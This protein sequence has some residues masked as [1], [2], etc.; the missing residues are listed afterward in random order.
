MIDEFFKPWVL[1][2]NLSPSLDCDALL[3]VRI[4]STMISDLFT[5]TGVHCQNP[6]TYSNRS[7]QREQFK[8]KNHQTRVRPHSANM[9]S[10]SQK[11]PS[12]H[13]KAVDPLYDGLSQAD[14]TILKTVVDEN[15]RA[16]G[17]IRLFPTSDSWEFYSQYLEVRSTTHNMMLHKKL[18]PRR[19]Q[20]GNSPKKATQP[21]AKYVYFRHG[22]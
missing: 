9:T 3:D 5:L 17:W 10:N 13:H 14:Q 18:F 7:R 8:T 21:R 1:E 22:K 2:V 11:T 4:K 16:N 6:N 15:S 20:S 12:G 19:W